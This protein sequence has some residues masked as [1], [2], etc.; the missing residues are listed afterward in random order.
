MNRS[1]RVVHVERVFL[2]RNEEDKSWTWTRDKP[3]DLEPG[4]LAVLVADDFTR[5]RGPGSGPKPPPPAEKPTFSKLCL[6]PVS[7][8]VVVSKDTRTWMERIYGRAFGDEEDRVHV[9]LVGRMPSAL[10]DEW[11]KC[12]P[13][14][15]TNSTPSLK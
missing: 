9:E 2:N 13:G 1:A 4:K 15:M 10:P 6:I 8:A 14:Q 11:D 3:F 5:D 7:V 12:D